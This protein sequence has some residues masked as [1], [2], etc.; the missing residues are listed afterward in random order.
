MIEYYIG[1]ELKEIMAEAQAPRDIKM[2]SFI[3]D[4]DQDE[5]GRKCQKWK[6][7]LTTRFR[8][9][10]IN[11]RL[12][13]LNIDGGE[14]MRK[15]VENLSAIWQEHAPV[16]PETFPSLSTTAT[17]KIKVQIKHPSRSQWTMKI[18]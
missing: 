4:S 2:H 16:V 8:F 17:R 12:D 3:A 15:L 9:F 11:D 10:H 14:M 5:T 18:G 13:E 1:D 6:S 7:E